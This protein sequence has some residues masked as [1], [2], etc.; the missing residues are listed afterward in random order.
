MARK[1]RPYRKSCWSLAWLVI[2]FIGPLIA[3][4]IYFTVVF[5]FALAKLDM[6]IALS[7]AAFAAASRSSCGPEL[8][9]D[10][11]F[12]ATRYA[13]RPFI[14]QRIFSAADTGVCLKW[15]SD[16]LEYGMTTAAAQPSAPLFAANSDGSGPGE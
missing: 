9:M 7:S 16:L 1:A 2:G 13:D 6:T 8:L 11:R 15:N 5:I 3:L 4:F 10:V 14:Q 12:M